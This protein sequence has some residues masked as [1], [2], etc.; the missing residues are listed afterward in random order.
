MRPSL[1]SRADAA[2]GGLRGLLSKAWQSLFIASR[3]P[4]EDRLN[5][6]AED[7]IDGLVARLKADM[8]ARF[9]RGD[10]PSAAEYF[11]AYPELAA[12]KEKVLSLAYEE[13]C[14][15]EENHQ[16]PDTLEFCERYQAWTNSLEEQ[17]LVHKGISQAVNAPS[18]IKP[19]YPEPGENFGGFLIISELGQG[20]AARVYLARDEE[21]GLR[22]VV[23]KVSADRGNEASIQ[24]RL[25]H[26]HIIPVL[27]VTRPPESALRGLCMPFRPGLPLDQ[28]I[29][30]LF[31]GEKQP[32]S[33]IEIWRALAPRG[34]D[35]PE[36]PS[37]PGWKDF[38]VRGTYFDGVAWIIERIAD[39]LHY[40]HRRGIFHR[41][42][43]PANIFLTM[44]EGPQL[45]DFNL[46]HAPHAPEQAVAAQ[47]GGTL[48]Y[49]APEQLRAFRSAECWDDVT[50]V[51][52]V[53]SLAV[54]A[55]ELLEGKPP[56]EQETQKPLAQTIQNLLDTRSSANPWPSLR[57]SNPSIPHALTAIIDLCVEADPNRRYPDADALAKDLHRFRRRRPLLLALNPSRSERATNWTVRNRWP[58]AIS[59]SMVLIA[60]VI[61]GAETA[62][63]LT[64]YEDRPEFQKIVK[65]HETR[66]HSEARSALLSM[67]AEGWDFPLLWIYLGTAYEEK[68][69]ET[70]PS[71]TI[72]V[73]C[74][75]KLARI[76]RDP[77][78]TEKLKLWSN[79]HKGFL[80]DLEQLAIV[81]YKP[82][83]KD[84]SAD[85]ASLRKRTAGEILAF[86]QGLGWDSDSKRAERAV[87][88]EYIDDFASADRL[89]AKE[90]QVRSGTDL[91]SLG[92]LWPVLYLSARASIKQASQLLESTQLISEAPSIDRLL[93]KVSSNIYHLDAIQAR[94]AQSGVLAAAE[95][96]RWRYRI[97]WLKCEANL[98][99]GDLRQ[100]QGRI[101]EAT[102]FYAKASEL[103]VELSPIAL[104]SDYFSELVQRVLSRRQ[105]S[106]SLLPMENSSSPNGPVLVGSSSL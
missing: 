30:R 55:R 34:G 20:G 60:L 6:S 97:D 94:L 65:T 99:E 105:P 49:M 102:D 29:A 91:H 74:Q 100:K 68:D 96:R 8:H 31:E 67:I 39:A 98:A 4:R 48:P 56:V 76:W 46:A 43:K 47:R 59:G 104:E 72:P 2:P 53:Y 80:R 63:W 14:L 22:E 77:A 37:G 10:R 103:L 33:A 95:V 25:D 41:D 66:P 85:H 58:L 86:T 92:Q 38:P 70:V 11:Q 82:S 106:S 51:S 50:G 78:Q 28:V 5:V 40:A 88:F 44:S 57:R 83:P 45:L 89:I 7:T 9:A 73:V 101:R 42:V 90:I 23:L 12:N 3:S 62:R 36:A 87:I 19:R 18:F 69:G 17:L 52:D 27:S 16:R 79:S 54:V 93:R 1:D 64:P 61:A 75:Q 81:L 26:P 71:E 21:L 84:E 13:F 15:L 24:G 35:H 32:T